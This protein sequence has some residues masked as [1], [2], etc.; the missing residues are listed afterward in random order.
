MLHWMM[1]VRMVHW[2]GTSVMRLQLETLKRGNM[3]LVSMSFQV[4]TTVS[5][6]RNII[7]CI[8]ILYCA[9][10][11]VNNIVKPSSWKREP[12]MPRF[13]GRLREVV[14]WRIKLMVSLSRRVRDTSTFW[15]RIYC[16]QFVSYV[17]CACSSM[18]HW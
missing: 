7:L 18:F 8:I 13:S 4:S 16:T 1:T 5:C 11:I 2:E 3:D 12:K 9:L 15:Q 10:F 6:F 14:T 17:C